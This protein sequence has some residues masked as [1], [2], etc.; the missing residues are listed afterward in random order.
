[1]PDGFQI[2]GL[3]E[4]Q[5]KIVDL[6]PELIDELDFAAR[7]A[8]ALWEQRAKED[9]PKDQGRLASAIT[10]MQTGFLEYDTVSPVEYSAYLEWGTRGKV[11]VPAE[12]ADYAIQFKGSG[13]GG[14]E[15]AKE[16]IF[17]WMKRV[18]I[19]E[20]KQ[21]AVF[22]SIMINGIRPHPCFFIQMPFVQN[23]LNS[24][25]ASILNTPH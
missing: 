19:A 24:D 9:A 15:T 4:L 10:S 16:M 17:A 3:P 5:S 22:A 21:W 1:M 11:N 18:G 2:Q 23:Q 14:G 20:D 25:I 13:S 12:L 8:A 7:D 6:Y